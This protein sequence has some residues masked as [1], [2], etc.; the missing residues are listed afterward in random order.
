MQI[1]NAF[2]YEK[3]KKDIYLQMNEAMKK[4]DPNEEDHC[5]INV[6]QQERKRVLS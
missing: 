5:C 4:T 2:L 3:K 1:A 6:H